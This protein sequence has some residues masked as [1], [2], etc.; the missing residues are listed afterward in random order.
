M[1]SND[2]GLKEGNCGRKGHS[3]QQGE[4]LTKLI[5][6]GCSLGEELELPLWTFLQLPQ[7]LISAAP[8]ESGGW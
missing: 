6:L 4:L 3:P 7:L 2:S 5:A 8:K 1:G